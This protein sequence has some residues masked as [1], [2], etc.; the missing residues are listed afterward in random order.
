MVIILPANPKKVDM[1]KLMELKK[2]IEKEKK[3]TEEELKKLLAEKVNKL[4]EKNEY[5][6]NAPPD[7]RL[8][9]MQQPLEKQI[10]ILDRIDWA[11]KVA[12]LYTKEV[13]RDSVD[14]QIE[15]WRFLGEQDE[16]TLDR[17]AVALRS[18]EQ[19]ESKKLKERLMALKKEQE[20]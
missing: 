9:L 17:T 10:A 18:L 15:F 8:W 13:L 5:F 11:S 19:E 16:K 1:K 2:K 4:F 12:P 20:K 6:Q 3:G 7:V 14:A